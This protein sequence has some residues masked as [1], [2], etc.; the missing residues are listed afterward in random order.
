MESI[1]ARKMWLTLEPYHAA[2]YFSPE[3]YEAYAALGATHPMM[4]YF[5]SRSAPMG[6]CSPGL[7][8]ATFYNFHPSYVAKFIPKA[9]EIATPAKFLGARLSGA[10]SMLR[11]FLGEAVNSREIGEA[12]ELARRAASACE[13]QGRALFAAHANLDWPEEPHLAL[14]HAVALLREFRGDGH[15]AAL[16]I[17]GIDGCESLVTHAAVGPVPA[18]A[19]KATRKWSDQEWTAAEDRLKSRGLIDASGALTESG[20]AVRD[21]IEERTDELAMAPWLALGP[22]DCTRLRALVRPFSK[23]I[24]EAGGLGFG[25]GF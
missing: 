13:P 24:V 2:I 8:A 15:L 22:D 17:E 3:A 10:D 14:W 12:L 19:L 1:V 20:R 9:W 4:G 23:A 16:M 5:A 18:E 6:E 25:A 21:R 11:R 7:V